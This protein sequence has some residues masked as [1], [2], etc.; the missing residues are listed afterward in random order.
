MLENKR[1]QIWIETVIYTLIA[2]ILI[3]AVLAFVKPK[4]TELQDKAIIE[5]SISLM[6]DFDQTVME[7]IQGGSGNKR[8][9]ET[10]I[11]KG[12]L[13][14]D[15]VSDELIFLIEGNYLYSEP[16]REIQDG[17]LILK[18][19]KAGDLNIITIN[20]TYE[21]Y[22]ITFNGNDEGKII[23]K[24]STPYKLSITNRGKKGEPDLEKW[25]VDIEIA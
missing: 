20:R 7:V 3:A 2:F 24:A 22:N 18:T 16:G 1:G 25:Q 12:D 19:E 5:Q 6:K 21:E 10:S 13:I 4:I 17:N 11:K 23:S 15:G 9:L 8:I 14:I